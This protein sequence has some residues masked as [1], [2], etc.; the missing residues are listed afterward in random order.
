MNFRPIAALL[1]PLALAACM[2]PGTSDLVATRY[3]FGWVVPTDSPVAAVFDD[4]SRTYVTLRGQGGA[5]SFADDDG[6][7]LTVRHVAPY[8]I[9]E[10]VRPA[11]RVARDGASTRITLPGRS[12]SDA[13]AGA[14]TAPV[15][16]AP[17][18]TRP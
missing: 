7:P 1:L 5:P 14:A 6:H 11:F 2:T 8:Y 12:T 4:G 18:A 16:A 9:I 15:A 17:G 10:G 13:S 3:H